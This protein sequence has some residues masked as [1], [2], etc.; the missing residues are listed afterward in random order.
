MRYLIIKK[1]TNCFFN[2]TTFILQK[3]LIVQSICEQFWL[4][5]KTRKCPNQLINIRKQDLL[6][7]KKIL[8]TSGFMRELNL[9]SCWNYLS[10]LETINYDLGNSR[11]NNNKR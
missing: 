9:K 6:N 8:D 4:N 11:L 10:N 2:D 5:L 1:L 3:Y 7:I